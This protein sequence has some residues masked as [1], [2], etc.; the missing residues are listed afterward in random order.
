[1]GVVEIAVSKMSPQAHAFRR[2]IEYIR[3]PS[4]PSATP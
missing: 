3:V 4:T 1:M 2:F